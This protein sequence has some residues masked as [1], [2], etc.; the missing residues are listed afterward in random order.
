VSNLSSSQWIHLPLG[1]MQYRIKTT[2][3]AVVEIAFRDTDFSY[4]LNG[5]IEFVPYASVKSI[6]LKNNRN[7]VVALPL[8]LSIPTGEHCLMTVQLETDLKQV[9]F[10]SDTFVKHN[11]QETKDIVE[12]YTRLAGKSFEMRKQKVLRELK[13]NRC[14]EI[15][16]CI[17][18]IGGDKVSI[19]RGG[20]TITISQ[21]H[22]ATKEGQSVIFTASRMG[23]FGLGDRVECELFLNGDVTVYLL[24]E[25]FRLQISNL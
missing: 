10:A 11:T 23:L 17:F 22:Y 14:C 18:A 5:S 3:G 13:T 8:P 2:E 24:K 6:G 15:G 21:P 20:K 4:D 19:S 16:E 25:I 9:N 12:V 1:N 7:A